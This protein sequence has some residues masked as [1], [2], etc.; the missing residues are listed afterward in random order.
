LLVLALFMIVPYAM[1]LTQQDVTITATPSYISISNTPSSHGFGLVGTS[2]NFST[3]QPG[4]NVTNASTI[5]ID[6][7]IGTNSTTWVDTSGGTPWDHDDGG[8][9]GADQAALYA[10]NDTGCWCIIV[11][12]GTP[13]NLVSDWPATTDFDWEFRLMTPTS[14]SDGYEKAI[15]VELVASAA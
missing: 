9:A 7:A 1:A 12:N 15:K 13:N 10:S 5:A 8:A 14:F 2:S 4:F 11:K 3:T 6:V